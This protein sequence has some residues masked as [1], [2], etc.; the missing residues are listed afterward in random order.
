MTQEQLDGI[1][2]AFENHTYNENTVQHAHAV[3]AGTYSS[4]LKLILEAQNTEEFIR[5]KN[6]IINRL[7]ERN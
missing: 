5:A 2:K 1:I 4:M 3:M 6:S 7:K